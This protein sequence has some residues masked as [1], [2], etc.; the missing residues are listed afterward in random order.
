M[1]INQCADMSSILGCDLEQSQTGV[2]MKGK[3]PHFPQFSYDIKRIH[4]LM[5]YSDFLEYKIVSD[6]SRS[7]GTFFDS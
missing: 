3:G 2:I 4:S 6:T 7:L 1:F 5:I